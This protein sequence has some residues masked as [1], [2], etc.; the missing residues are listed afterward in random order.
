MPV[1]FSFPRHLRKGA[2]DPE[3]AQERNNRTLVSWLNTFVPTY[4]S[5]GTTLTL[6]GDLIVSNDL[7]VNGQIL[8]IGHGEIYVSTPAATTISNTS[9][10][11]EEAST[12]TLSGNNHSFDMDTNG[13]LRYTGT[14]DAVAHIA[15]SMSFTSASNNQVIHMR[16]A[17][18][19]TT[20]AASEIQRKTGAAGDVGSSALHAF[21]TMSTNDYL[22]LFVRNSTAATDITMQTTN[23]FAMTM[24]AA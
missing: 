3:V 17:K 10:Y 6:P 15:L 12:Y 5:D 7:T 21:T 11:Y 19:G 22:S 9:T 16:V 14:V 24:P 1:G 2:A 8:S 13:R 23:L 20:L 18:N 4:D